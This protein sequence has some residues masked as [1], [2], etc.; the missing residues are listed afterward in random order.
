MREGKE[1]GV[2]LN[3]TAPFRD[4]IRNEV[5]FSRNHRTDMIDQERKQVSLQLRTMEA[6]GE[7]EFR[8]GTTGLVALSSGSKFGRTTT[9]SARLEWNPFEHAGGGVHGVVR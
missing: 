7:V 1:D 5:I 9:W 8:N 2:V 3:A 6:A 4:C